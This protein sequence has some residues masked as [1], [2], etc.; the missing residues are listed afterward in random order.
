MKAKHAIPALTEAHIKAAFDRVDIGDTPNFNVEWNETKKRFDIESNELLHWHDIKLAAGF[1][2]VRIK[3]KN[4]IF[5]TD[6]IYGINFHKCT[7]A[8]IKVRGKQSIVFADEPLVSIFFS[9]NGLYDDHEWLIPSSTTVYRLTKPSTSA[10][11]S[12][13]K[14]TRTFTISL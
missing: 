5:F 14:N 2:T 6:G 3:A 8:S 7:T 10:K 9:P 1:R 4:Q 13:R 12:I 11:G